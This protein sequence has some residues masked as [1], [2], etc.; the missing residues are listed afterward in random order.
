MTLFII[1]LIL[2]SS[3]N[4]VIA[5]TGDSDKVEKYNCLNPFEDICCRVECPY[6]GSC[7]TNITN[8]H[9]YGYFMNDCCAEIILENNITCN[10]TSGQEAPCIIIDKKLN[11]FE[12]FI[13]F[14]KTGPIYLVVIV[15]VSMFTGV[16]FIV[17]ACC[18]FG[19]KR[20]PL[21]YKYLINTLDNI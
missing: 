4:L 15:A 9:D 19:K 1:S 13:K 16:A 21:E 5:D 7:Q 2:L 8:Y 18:I 14:F 6:C 11:D 12:R 10:V 3:I 17:Y 20:P